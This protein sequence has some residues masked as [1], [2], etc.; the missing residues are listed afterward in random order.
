MRFYSL[1]NLTWL[2]EVFMAVTCQNDGYLDEQ[3]V[4]ELV[5]KLNQS[6]ST[7]RIRLKFKVSLCL[8]GRYVD[9]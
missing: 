7:N 5:Q 2:N 8:C 1:T 6:I 3:E 9:K 4:V